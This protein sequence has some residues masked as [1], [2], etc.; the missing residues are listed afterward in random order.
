M[1]AHSDA[2]SCVCN[3]TSLMFTSFMACFF[4]VVSQ[5]ELCIGYSFTM[6]LAGRMPTCNTIFKVQGGANRSAPCSGEGQRIHR[7]RLD[8]AHAGDCRAQRT[9]RRA[10]RPVA[11]YAQAGYEASIQFT[12]AKCGLYF[13]YTI[14]YL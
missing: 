9:D 6:E 5:G 2:H 1:F 14:R 8:A 7:Q 4:T 11:G 3:L 10:V 13:I 12:H